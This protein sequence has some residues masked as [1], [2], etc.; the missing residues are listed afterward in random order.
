MMKMKRLLAVALSGMMILGCCGCGNTGSQQ[1]NNGD[2]NNVQTGDYVYTPKE[3]TITTWDYQVSSTA[4]SKWY[5][6][7]QEKFQE[8][9]PEITLKIESVPA[10]SASGSVSADRVAL[11]TGMAAGTAPTVYHAGHFSVMQQWI[12]AGYAYPLDEYLGSFQDYDKIDPLAMEQATYNGSVYGI[13]RMVYVLNLAYRKDAYQEAG[14]DPNK[15]PTTWDELVEYSKKLTKADGSQYG[16]GLI[17]ATVADWWF[18]IFAWGADAEL[19]TVDESGKVSI[20]FTD[21][22]VVEALQFYHDLKWKHKVLQS[23]TGASQTSLIQDF[24]AGRCA[25]TIFTT[26]NYAYAKQCGLSDEDLGLA[27]IP[28][29][30]S[31]NE[32][33]ANGGGYYFI[34]ASATKE[35]RDAAWEYIQFMTS[36]EAQKEL[37]E[38][39]GNNGVITPYVS[40]YK[41]INVSDYIDYEENLGVALQNAWNNSRRESVLVEKL[42]PYLNPVIEEV[43]VNRSADLEALLKKAEKNANADVIS[44]YN[45][46]K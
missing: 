4:A 32:I 36:E 38:Y 25:Q 12:E 28:V 11:T 23:D 10:Q 26:E 29:G 34:N 46:G 24:A 19:S 31:G 15:P 5:Q 14:L 37:Y 27:T 17:S 45:S 18:Q 16:L 44:I 8:L 20:N 6:L 30:P 3:V 1:S 13:P 43:M 21:K 7:R 33:T 22:K 42:R 35:E 41:T 39:L 2:K 40:F 9:Y